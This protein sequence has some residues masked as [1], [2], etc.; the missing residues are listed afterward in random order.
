[1][2]SVAERSRVDAAGAAADV[3]TLGDESDERASS[4]PKGGPAAADGVAAPTYAWRMR[5]VASGQTPAAPS[6]SSRTDRE[7]PLHRR[8]LAEVSA[9]DAKH[10]ARRNAAPRDERHLKEKIDEA[11]RK[12]LEDVEEADV[13]VALAPPPA[14]SKGPH[15]SSHLVRHNT[16]RAWDLTPLAIAAFRDARSDATKKRREAT[17]SRRLNLVDDET[18]RRA[19]KWQW[20]MHRVA[21]VAAREAISKRRATWL[22]A[23]V[24]ANAFLI[25]RRA[26][27]DPF[28]RKKHSPRCQAASLKLQN[29]FRDLRRERRW[30]ALHGPLKMVKKAVRDLVERKRRAK[31][32]QRR[33]DAAEILQF[34][35]APVMTNGN[36]WR[37]ACFLY[38]RHL[39]RVQH[40][41]RGYVVSRRFR[42]AGL[43]RAWAHAE[44]DL[45]HKAPGETI[46]PQDRK[47]GLVPSPGD[48]L[49]RTLKDARRKT[50]RL[51]GRDAGW[52]T[53]SE[54]RRESV[55]MAYR[56]I[57]RAH[58]ATVHDFLIQTR[59]NFVGG[60]RRMSLDDARVLVETGATTSD[61]ELLADANKRPVV[62]FFTEA[63]KLFVSAM[64][65]F[66][67][68]RRAR[69]RKLDP[70]Y[71]LALLAQVDEYFGEAPVARKAP[72]TG[73]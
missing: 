59:R 15:T 44:H 69:Q 64:K 56:R 73:L 52:R 31:D 68:E 10:R 7:S 49:K 36:R 22:A 67:D 39:R 58:R 29:W 33:R 63:P 51:G 27:L 40:F 13:V 6:R 50:A 12:A 55:A 26:S 3:S 66:Y 41:A 32:A 20:K 2:D 54:F 8:R 4:A 47:W 71:D 61:F 70:A 25:F 42:I 21:L 48:A 18:T 34:V 19:A 38:M 16:C 9:L 37:K 45:Y 62:P 46:G 65:G 28:L 72:E 30:A 60:V 17:S 23:V 53:P 43:E 1:M 5:L 57:Q 35:C 11:K 14:P 24:S